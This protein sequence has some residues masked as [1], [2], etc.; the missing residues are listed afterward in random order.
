WHSVVL[1]V[2]ALACYVVYAA[3][4]GLFQGSE[5]ISLAILKLPLIIIASVVLCVPSFY[6]FTALSGVDHS[7]RQ[8]ATVLT[9]FCATAGLILLALMP[10][11]WLFTV[12]SRSL[13]FVVWLNVFMA[14]TAIA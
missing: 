13:E 7:P 11:L 4:A 1:L 12:S 3:A 8:L 10:I 14:L 6:V 2:G 5:G 9:G